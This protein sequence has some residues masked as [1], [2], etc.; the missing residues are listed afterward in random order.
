MTNDDLIA[1]AFN[2][3][4]LVEPNV[5]AKMVGSVEVL[6]D[7]AGIITKPTPEQIVTDFNTARKNVLEVI[8]TS[9][10]AIVELS[11]IAHQ[12]GD[13][14]FYD[15]LTSALKV[16]LEANRDL[17]DMH[18]KIQKLT[19][20][21]GGAVKSIQNNLFIGSTSDLQKMLDDLKKKH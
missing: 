19:E 6:P 8:D 15:S 16:M 1:R 21:I 11:D 3:T 2:M 20:N 9:R 4:P 13:D 14:K 10:D 18:N 5:V 7:G 12:S 17:L